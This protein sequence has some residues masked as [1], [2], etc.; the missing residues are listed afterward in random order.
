MGENK[1]LLMISWGCA[2]FIMRVLVL[3]G[4]SHLIMYKMM[5]NSLRAAW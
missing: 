4:I 5:I 3:A 2:G 1:S